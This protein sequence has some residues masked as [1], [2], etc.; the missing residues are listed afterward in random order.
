MA[1]MRDRLMEL[2]GNVFL[3][4]NE[5][6]AFGSYDTVGETTLGYNDKER[7]AD[8]LL[9]NGVILPPCKVGDA[10]YQ[11]YAD[12]CGND[13]CM[14]TCESCESATWKIAEM[15]FDP[16]KDFDKTVFFTREEAE[17]ALREKEK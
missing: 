11:V 7:I 16:F 3:P 12:D 4:I 10:V 6:N 2:L 13:G 15:Q 5:R 8:H 14:G 1:D 9:A 17:K